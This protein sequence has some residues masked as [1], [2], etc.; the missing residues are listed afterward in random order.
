MDPSINYFILPFFYSVF[1]LDMSCLILE[2]GFLKFL[3]WPCSVFNFIDE[4]RIK[5]KYLSLMIYCKQLLFSFLLK[6]KQKKKKINPTTYSYHHC[7]SAQI[8]M[9]RACAFCSSS[10]IAELRSLVVQDNGK[11]LCF[12][13]NVVINFDRSNYWVFHDVSARE[14]LMQSQTSVASQFHFFIYT[15]IYYPQILYKNVE[16]I[17][18]NK[19][20]IV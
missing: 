4:S 19:V 2:S 15:Y 3:W 20:I 11:T 13:Y 7:R 10:S 14:L 12:A 18:K 17:H 8:Y 9:T 5:P 16:E 1:L 6:K